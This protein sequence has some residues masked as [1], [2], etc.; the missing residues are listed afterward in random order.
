MRVGGVQ[1]EEEVGLRYASEILGRG[2]R[3]GEEKGSGVG[4][5]KVRIASALS[6]IGCRF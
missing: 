4:E 1:E 3:G 5:R 6:S 2:T